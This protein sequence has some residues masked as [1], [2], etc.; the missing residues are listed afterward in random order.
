MAEVLAPSLHMSRQ[1]LWPSWASGGMRA[2]LL[3]EINSRSF[4][5]SP[6]SCYGMAVSN[7][8]GRRSALMSAFLA[9]ADI[10]RSSCDVRIVPGAD[11]LT[12]GAV[13]QAAGT[14]GNG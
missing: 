9:K 14:K 6:N 7:L 8:E 11:V 1:L 4:G 2:L 13:L 12:N 3:R 5:R 10:A